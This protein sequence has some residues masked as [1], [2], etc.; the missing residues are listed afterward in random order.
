MSNENA[1]KLVRIASILLIAFGVF[2]AL[3]SVP[4]L[5]GPTYAFID[6]VDWPIDGNVELDSVAKMLCAIAGGL[7]AG[8]GVFMYLIVAPLVERGDPLG[9]KAIPALLVWYVV[10]SG[11]S[12]LAGA[13][14][15]AV[16]NAAFLALLIAPLLLVG[17]AKAD[18]AAG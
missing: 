6:L 2:F 16:S 13:P 14:L 1:A 8:F 9:R 10:D 7:S 4:V 17:Q 5:A 15:N 11:G 18:Q 12:V 3:V